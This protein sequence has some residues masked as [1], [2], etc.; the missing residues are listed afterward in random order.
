MIYT[1]TFNP[2]L[3]YTIRIKGFEVGTLN[4]TSY[5]ELRVGG[6][7]VN[8]SI[9]LTSLGVEN[10]A[11][12]FI[13]GFTGDQIE[14]GMQKLGCKTDFIRLPQGFSRI[15]VKLQDEVE[16]E[17]NGMG[18]AVSIAECERFMMIV[19]R[20]KPGDTLVLSGSIPA[21]MPQDIYEQIL[22]AVD[23][24][25]IRVVVDTS[26]T[27][28]RRTL[29]YRPFLIK[30]NLIELG[31]LFGRSLIDYDDIVGCAKHLQEEGARN[32]LVSMGSAGAILVTSDGQ[33][34]SAPA[35]SGDLVDS[36]G[37]GDS[38]V[39]GFLAGYLERGSMVDGFAKGLAAGSATAYKQ[40]LATGEEISAI[41]QRT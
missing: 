21:S 38:M 12:G 26:S 7:G 17:M 4:R 41:A 37:A 30:P 32:V 25:K 29:A 22:D 27:L 31:E 35:P 23:T 18:P 40:G 33:V 36:I 28:L 14:A 11:L 9:V 19:K 8:V 13:A 20:L 6:K 2:S 34:F 15:N 1:I 10:I 39:A 5:E 24:D 3:D 16:T